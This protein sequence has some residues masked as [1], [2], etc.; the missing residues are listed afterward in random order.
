MLEFE[1]SNLLTLASDSKYAIIIAQIIL[2]KGN[3]ITLRDTEEIYA[4]DPTDGIYKQYGVTYLKEKVAKM[5]KK[6]YNSAIVNEAVN[7]IKTQTY[8]DRNK[9]GVPQGRIKVKN[10]TL[11]VTTRTLYPHSPQDL[12]LTVLPV[13]YDPKA[14]CPKFLSFLSQTMT[15]L[16]SELLQ[17][18]IGFCLERYY[19]YKKALLIV[20]PSNTGKTTLLR[21]LIFFIGKDNVSSI[22][23]HDLAGR[24]DKAELFGKK[25]NICDELSPQ[26]MTHTNQFKGLTGS[27]QLKAENKFKNPFVFT[28]ETKL[29]FATNQ[30]P[31]APNSNDDAFFERWLIIRMLN[32]FKGPN[33]DPHLFDKLTTSPELSGILNWALDG[34]DRLIKRGMFI[35]YPSLDEVKAEFGWVDSVALFVNDKVIRDPSA[36]IPK[37]TIYAYYTGYCGTRRFGAIGYQEFCKRIGQLQGVTTARLGGTPRVEAFR[38]IRL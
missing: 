7:Y 8:R 32:Q 27:S 28:S 33:A 18:M 36:T 3:Y 9:I 14:K 24:F 38:G 11:D 15:P 34:R 21:V 19:N 31:K 23:L 2:K 1:S 30:T 10:G 35:D 22:P 13:N 20:G 16:E 25:A 17:E 29:I 5:L 12:S 4:Y 37:Q 6:K 26:D